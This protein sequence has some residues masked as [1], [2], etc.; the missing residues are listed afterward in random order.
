VFLERLGRLHLYRPPVENLIA[1][2]LIRAAP[3]DLEDITFLISRHRPDRDRI[4]QII[5]AFAQPAREK[6]VESLVY[7]DVLRP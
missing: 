4:R 5:A 3:K 6:A 7:L 1:A 2:K